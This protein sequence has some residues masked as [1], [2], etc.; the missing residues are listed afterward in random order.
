MRTLV[1]VLGAVVLLT[2]ACGPRV[3][4]PSP[5]ARPAE[6]IASKTPDADRAYRPPNLP[7]W[8]GETPECPG[9]EMKQRTLSWGSVFWCH[10]PGHPVDASLQNDFGRLA[11]CVH[12]SVEAFQTEPGENGLG[13]FLKRASDAG[14][15]PILCGAVRRDSEVRTYNGRTVKYERIIAAPAEVEGGPATV[16]YR[17]GCGECLV[18]SETAVG[19]VL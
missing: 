7:W 5:Q 6:P 16:R 2:A 14:L 4:E 10:L 15:N 8:Q 3:S 11:R 13:E 19:V 18:A 12:E 9:G 1:L 17:F